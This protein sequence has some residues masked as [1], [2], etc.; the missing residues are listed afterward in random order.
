MSFKPIA[1]LNIIVIN[2]N[3]FQLLESP[4]RN[5][6]IKELP[7][8]LMPV[9]IAYPVPIGIVCNEKL[10]RPRA[11]PRPMIMKNTVCQLLATDSLSIIVTAKVSNRPA[12]IKL[13]QAINN[14]SV[15]PY[16]LINFNIYN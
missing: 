7:T 11:P 14:P 16:R 12:K 8:T 6:P 1:E 15:P 5:I 2:N 13:N 10:S 3:L 9:Q 4:K